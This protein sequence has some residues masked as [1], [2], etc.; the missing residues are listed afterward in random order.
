LNEDHTCKRASLVATGSLDYIK[1]ADEP[2]WLVWNTNVTTASR[3]TNTAVLVSCKND[4]YL[5]SFEKIGKLHMHV[6]SHDAIFASVAMVSNSKNASFGIF[7]RYTLIN[8]FNIKFSCK[9]K[10]VCYTPTQ[11][12]RNNNASY[13]HHNFFLI[14]VLEWFTAWNCSFSSLK[15]KTQMCML[16]HMFSMSRYFYNIKFNDFIQLFCRGRK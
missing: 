11:T 6:A 13:I 3:S 1:T 8:W 4:Q 12:L 16:Y 10:K 7:L 14:G 5:M 2:R 15:H 9:H